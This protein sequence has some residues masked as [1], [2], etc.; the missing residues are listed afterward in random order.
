MANFPDTPARAQSPPLVEVIPLGRVNQTA[1][2]VVAANLQAIFGLNADIA[3]PWPEP[4]YALVPTRGQYDAGP[5][6]KALAGD[7]MVPPLRVGLT[8]LDLCLP[9]LSYVFGEAQ[10]EGRAAVVSTH[11]LRES[12][13]GGQASRSLMLERLA[14]VA[15]HEA[16]HVLG[17]VHCRSPRCLMNFS[18]GLASL[19]RLGAALCPAC[20]ALLAM[21]RRR[22]LAG[23]DRAPQ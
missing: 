16:A 20:Q 10:M 13:Q 9:F 7:G 8:R 6:L 1:A 3:D 2:A 12:P 11:R 22:L 5:I 23:V 4:D 14:K 18:P 15:L 19:D 17:L 21:R